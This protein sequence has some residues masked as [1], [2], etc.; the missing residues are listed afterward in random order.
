[1]LEH[2][3]DASISDRR[4]PPGVDLARPKLSVG[5]NRDPHLVSEVP[6]VR[7]QQRCGRD[8]PTVVQPDRQPVLERG[9]AWRQIVRHSTH[10]A[11]LAAGRPASSIWGDAVSGLSVARCE[12]DEG[13]RHAAAGFRFAGQVELV[14]DRPDMTLHRA[15]GDHE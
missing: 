7:G 15:L 14:E 10:R 1:M 12:E 8:R 3:H 4:H 9:R 13:R 6:R 2:E 11:F 5:A